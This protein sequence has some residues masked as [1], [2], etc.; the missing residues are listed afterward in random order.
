VIG[1]VAE[2]LEALNL[3]HIG[4]EFI[5]ENGAGAGGGGKAKI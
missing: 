2:V 5:A 3:K 4:V 1:N